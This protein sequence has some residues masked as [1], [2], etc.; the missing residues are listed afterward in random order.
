M[1]ANEAGRSVAS[2]IFAIFD[3]F[4]GHG[5]SL[6]LS[7]IAELSG[8]PL[9]TC[10]RVV[11]ELEEW[12][13][14]ARDSQGRYQIG[15]RLWELG[16]N[17][18]RRLRD[19]ARPYLQ[20][21]FSLS[22]ET[23]HLAVREGNEALYVVRVYGSK[24]VP[25]ASRIG[26]RL[27]LHATAVGKV[28]LA[29]EEPWFRDTYLAG[30]LRSLTPQTRIDPAVLAGELAEIAEQGYAVTAEEARADACSI[31]VPVYTS[32]GPNA[33]GAAIGLVTLASQLPTVT[34]HLP[35]LTG[36]ARRIAAA[37]QHRPSLRLGN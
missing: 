15:I 23:A 31:A 7:Q 14:L 24:R 11:G 2:R 36:I 22:G 37:I 9:S 19:T 25:Q 12:G 35:A 16:Q 5:P 26:G 8:L 33:V 3:V 32:V 21:L 28:M 4:E 30:N 13:G 6:S 29:Y 1:R 10:H 34:Q 17:A 27:P 18:G 20:D